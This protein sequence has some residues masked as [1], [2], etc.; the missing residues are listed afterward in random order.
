[1]KIRNMNRLAIVVIAV[2]ACLT[3]FAQNWENSKTVKKQLVNA[4]H[5]GKTYY[6]QYNIYNPRKS[7]KTTSNYTNV[8]AVK[9]YI[10]GVD[11]YYAS[12]TWHKK[13]SVSTSRAN[14]IKI[15][16]EAWKENRAIPSFSWHLENPYAPSNFGTIQAFR[17]IDH[18]SVPDYPKEHHSVIAEIVWEKGDT[19]GLGNYSGKDN[20][21]CYPN[22][23]AWFIDRCKEVADIIN[24][25]VDENGKPIPFLFRLWHEWEDG[26]AWWGAKYTS[27]EDYKK[28]FILTE[29]TIKK[30]APQ[31]QILWAYC[32]DR[33]W[34]TE[35]ML[36]SRYPGDQYV[37][38]IGF[39]DY[40]L[41][42]SEENF[43][44]AVQRAKIISKV[45]KEKKLATALF[46][47]N[48]N[49]RKI[50]EF[51]TKYLNRLLKTDGV[52][53]GIVQ[54][55]SLKNFNDST[56]MRNFLNKDNIIS[57]HQVARD[58]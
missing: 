27:V 23:R 2:T 40:A 22:P 33:H 19:C 5:K 29:Q 25:F 4:A 13:R 21:E 56:D 24:E 48:N 41:G 54:I 39:D 50:P 35:E 15:V 8:L 31:A 26:W 6:S 11:F 53:L 18:K 51:Y 47:T 44:S 49:K 12:G 38:V 46:E 58:A 1:M 42:A 52:N 32:P 3:S 14:L 20:R 16:K 45:A 55:W 43:Q 28:F 34:D 17:Y 7:D 30:H 36:M 9:P 10:Y 37:D 57:L